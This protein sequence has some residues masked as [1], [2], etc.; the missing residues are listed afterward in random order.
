M[1][2]VA[3]LSSVDDRLDALA[4]RYGVDTRIPT[5][6][7]ERTRR[8]AGY[9]RGPRGGASH[10]DSDIA[11]DSVDA[12]P[13]RDHHRSH[14]GLDR[15]PPSV[16]QSV[17]VAESDIDVTERGLHKAL[18][19]AQAEN[20]ELR[21]QLAVMHERE[22][23]IVT[24]SMMA[25]AEFS[26]AEQQIEQ[27]K[28]RVRGELKHPCSED[29]YRDIL[30]KPE[31][32]RNVVDVIRVVIHEQLHVAV[33]THDALLAK[34]EQL[35]QSHREAEAAVKRLEQDRA[36]TE[37]ETMRDLGLL[38][39]QLEL[40][41]QRA[42]I[43][44]E[45]AR[46]AALTIDGNQSKAARCD[47]AEA[48]RD[49]LRTLLEHERD[50]AATFQSKY[51]QTAAELVG[52]KEEHQRAQVL[53]HTAQSD[54][55]TLGRERDAL[56][57]RCRDNDH[58]ISTLETALL[59]AQNSRVEGS[60]SASKEREELRA[61]FERHLNAELS[62][63]REQY[64]EDLARMRDATR[65]ANERELKSA[66]EARDNESSEGMRL[67]AELEEA[68]T[69]L[70]NLRVLHTTKLEQAVMVQHDLKMQLSSKTH[71]AMRLDLQ[72]KEAEELKRALKTEADCL[73]RK[74]D[75]L[76]EDFYNLQAQHR[77]EQNA[78]N[79]KLSVQDEQLALMR[80][81]ELEAEVYLANVARSDTDPR[82]A[83]AALADIPASRKV[84]NAITVTRRAL[85]LE[86]E[87]EM[88]KTDKAAAE[89]KILSLTEQL[90][91]HKNALRHG[92]SPFTLFEEALD[93]KEQELERTRQ[94]EK[95]LR[96]QLTALEEKLRVAL[97]DV[98][99]LQAHRAELVR[100]KAYLQEVQSVLPPRLL[101]PSS[102]QHAQQHSYQHSH[103][104]H[105]HQ[106]HQHSHHHSHQH[107]QHQHH[108]LQLP[109][110]NISGVLQPG[111]SATLRSTMR[112]PLR[113][114]QQMRSPTSDSS[115][116]VYDRQHS[117]YHSTGTPLVPTSRPAIIT[118]QQG[119][120]R[121]F[122]GD[123]IEIS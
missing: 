21:K 30:S 94:V 48:D 61:T 12:T 110:A 67:R 72:L 54:A 8:A 45:I 59:E 119:N 112:S 90:D 46:N 40:F 60:H 11:A 123:A 74:L 97:Q 17:S 96:G 18:A 93:R 55:A 79:A 51:Q 6:S 37:A 116:L 34:V 66:R 68:K 84:T 1:A 50:N 33:S 78:V 25:K 22:M 19:Q 88:L 76:K 15:S 104:H 42:A 91:M 5:L 53:L 62:R 52:L 9:L 47:A 58:R 41:Q 57:A 85:S 87:V 81:M 43:A 27:L 10:S 20:R 122:V 16:D 102:Q 77:D 105:H 99:V 3:S 108:G 71:E 13:A 23:E 98:R 31:A 109:G 36:A 4:T 120:T 56:A 28:Q 100:I 118:Q 103:H 82:E 29:E 113:A 64:N 80:D 117:G 63:Y 106:H 65:E 73:L 89:A 95:I 114:S 86:N 111:L 83:A 69:A 38:R 26:A 92:N 39:S 121:V 32:S 49:R 101:L 107:H 7:N 2:A 75:I 70:E 44:E 14:R 115:G 24:L 35:S